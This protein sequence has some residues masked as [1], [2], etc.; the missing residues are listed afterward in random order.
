MDFAAVED[1][2]V[3]GLREVTQ[4]GLLGRVVLDLLHHLDVL[5]HLVA[6]RVGVV[7]HVLVGE[8]VGHKHLVQ[9]VDDLR[10]IL[11]ITKPPTLSGWRLLCLQREAF[12]SC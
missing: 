2:V 12:T 6:D 7:H 3:N 8:R 10:Q 4:Q 1:G 9:A 5:A 11:Q